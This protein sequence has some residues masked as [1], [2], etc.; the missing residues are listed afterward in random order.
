M[1]T[2]IT[3]IHDPRNIL[4]LYKTIHTL[5]QSLNWGFTL[6]R[7]PNDYLEIQD[8]KWNPAT[9]EGDKPYPSGDLLYLFHPLHKD[10]DP[11]THDTFAELRILP[12]GVVKPS[13]DLTVWPTHAL[14]DYWFGCVAMLYWIDT[15]TL[16]DLIEHYHDHWCPPEDQDS[17]GSFKNESDASTVH[18]HT[19]RSSARGTKVRGGRNSDSL[20]SQFDIGNILMWFYG[21]AAEQK[22]RAA[23]VARAANWVHSQQETTD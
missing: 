3:D 22:E 19:S 9:H 12:N 11:Q 4:T 7:V 23:S 1:Y 5:C 16:G 15:D 10:F 21:T 18:E 13:A 17:S 6:L 14:F 2:V 20:E 8:L